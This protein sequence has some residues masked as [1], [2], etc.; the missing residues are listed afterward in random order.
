M[1]QDSFGSFSE[2]RPCMNFVTRHLPKDARHRQIFAQSSYLAFAVLVLGLRVPVWL[3]ACFIGSCVLAQWA[4][5]PAWLPAK[6][7]APSGAPCLKSTSL[8]AM[9]TAMGLCLFLRTDS[10]VLACLAG[11][12]AIASKF[13]ITVGPRHPFNP[14][15]FA[16]FT[17]L[18]LSVVSEQKLFWTDAKQFGQSL[19]LIALVVVLGSITVSYAK[20]WR[21]TLGF[22]LSMA[23]FV[24]ASFGLGQGNWAKVGSILLNPTIWIFGFHM[25]SDPKAVPQ[26]AKSQVV[27]GSFVAAAFTSVALFFGKS[28]WAGIALATALF[29]VSALRW[30]VMRVRGSLE[31]PILGSKNPKLSQAQVL[32]EA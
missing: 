30:A 16:L 18:G 2:R 8:T 4:L 28:P 20:V 3:L 15:N 26:A 27:F 10:V 13:V 6:G 1:S 29:G 24:S 12:F 31:K 9:I 22:L 11:F 14:A 32:S 21:V 5:Q 23:I 25:I 19:G 7:T 17:T